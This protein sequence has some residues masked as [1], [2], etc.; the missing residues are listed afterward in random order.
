LTLNPGGAVDPAVGQITRFPLRTNADRPIFAT[1]GSR[2]VHRPLN[3]RL[4]IACSWC[5]RV[6]R[7]VGAEW[8]FHPRRYSPNV[9]WPKSAEVMIMTILGGMK[10]F[11]GPPVGDSCWLWLNQ[12][13]TNY[14]G[15]LAVRAR[16][17][18]AGLLFALPGGVTGRHRAFVWTYRGDACG[19]RD[20]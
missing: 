4:R 6:R 2:G 9:F 1:T 7:I 12:E 8:H 10:L 14:T 15:V 11:W 18:A 19:R 3:V 5:G 17:H 13:I 16:H 20:A